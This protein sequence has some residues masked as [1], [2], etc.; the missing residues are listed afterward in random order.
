M[1]IYIE[2]EILCHNVYISSLHLQ[3]MDDELLGL[4][5]LTAAAK[6][7]AEHHAE[8]GLNTG[9]PLDEHLDHQEVHR[10]HDAAR[11]QGAHH[12]GAGGLEL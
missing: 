2:F 12:T 4:E 3:Y 6:Q 11:H 8:D 1:Y 9:G 5:L 7:G 10:L